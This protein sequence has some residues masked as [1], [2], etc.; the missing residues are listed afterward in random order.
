SGSA[1][2]ALS[3][4]KTLA[5]THANDRNSLRSIIKR[6]PVRGAGRVSRAYYCCMASPRQA[7]GLCLSKEEYE[8]EGQRH[9]AQSNDMGMSFRSIEVRSWWRAAISTGSKCR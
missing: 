7:M 6:P 2:G 4:T 9:A 8:T 5:T 1:A 3:G